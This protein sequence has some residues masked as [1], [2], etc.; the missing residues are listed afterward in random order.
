MRSTQPL[1][2]YGQ[3]LSA[4]KT[5]LQCVKAKLLH[6]TQDGTTAPP[7][8]TSGQ[9]KGIH[10]A[11]LAIANAKHRINELVGC[12]LREGPH[13]IT[14][15][16]CDAVVLLA[17]FEYRRLMGEDGLV[18]LLLQ[19]PRG[20]LPEHDRSPEPIRALTLE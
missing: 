20:E 11:P 1:V 7:H 18:A 19:A 2:L 16:S 12:A 10:H 14:K 9:T 3:A 8:S 6:G 4:I 15:G 13:L 5:Y 17:A